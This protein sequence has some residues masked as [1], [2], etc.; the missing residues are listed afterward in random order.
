MES[1]EERLHRHLYDHEEPLVQAVYLSLAIVGIFTAFLG[2]ECLRGC[3]W[4]V[5]GA[6]ILWA[7]Q[8]HSVSLS[9]GSY[10]F[11]EG[12]EMRLGLTL[13]PQVFLDLKMG[14]AL[15]AQLQRSG[16]F[17]YVGINALALAGTLYFASHWRSDRVLNAAS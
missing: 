13:A 4:A 3:A 12:A 14:C 6:T 15:V 11:F 17:A 10:R 5:K 8:I 1:T 9:V 7:I 2:T 16:N